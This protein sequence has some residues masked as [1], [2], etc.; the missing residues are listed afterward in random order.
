MGALL[1]VF[2]EGGMNF[3][4]AFLKGKLTVPP[5]KWKVTLNHPAGCL[6]CLSNQGPDLG[7]ETIKMLGASQE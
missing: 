2:L 7:R 3:L 4:G 1:F 5:Q 6:G